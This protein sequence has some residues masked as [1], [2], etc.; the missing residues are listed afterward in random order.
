MGGSGKVFDFYYPFFSDEYRTAF[1]IAFCRHFFD[2]EICV[3]TFGRWKLYLQA[4][5][6]EN[7]GKW[8]PVLERWAEGINPFVS[9]FHNVSRETK[10]D[11]NS[12][13][14]SDTSSTGSG[15]SSADSTASTTGSSTGT[16]TT[17]NSGTNSSTTKTERKEQNTPQSQITDLKA[18]K[19]LSNA[20]ISDDSVTNNSSGTVSANT[21]ETNQV[22]NTNKT[23]GTTSTKADSNSKVNSEHGRIEK[24]SEHYEGLHGQTELDIVQKMSQI[25]SPYIM[26]FREMEPL[27]MGIWECGNYG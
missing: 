23:T 25:D 26:I 13:S 10:V 4:Y 19:Y 3:E 18:G 22:N 2:R 27:F 21:T 7:M 15:S 14:V 16:S 6:F 20:A 11:E 5:L 24:F 8:S 9:D 17:T 12:Q 1:Q